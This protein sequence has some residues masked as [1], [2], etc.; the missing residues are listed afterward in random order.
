MSDMML[1]NKKILITG[2]TG[3]VAKPVALAFAENN[4]VWGIAR[5]S[6]PDIKKELEDAGIT[7]VTFDLSEPD[8]SE[9]PNDFDYVLNFAVSFD[10]NFDAT[11]TSIV[12]GL[13]F[14][15]SH[16]RNAKAFI[17]CSTCGVYKVS[18]HEPMKE[19]D[20]LGDSHSAI[21]PAYAICK[22][23]AEGMARFCAKNWNIPTIIARLNVPYGDN[24]GW[25]SLH[26]ELILA[27][28]PVAVHTNKPSLFNPIHEDDIIATI[29][30]LIEAATI[31]ANIVNWA[32]TEQ[33]SL[34]EWSGYIAKLVGKSVD[35]EYTSDTLEST[36]ADTEKM[37]SITGKTKV[38]WQDGIRSMVKARH[39]EIDLKA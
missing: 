39:P 24:G 8:F 16:C 27:D 21:L 1:E 18:G 28:Q 26:M 4:D 7:C 10:P 36:V 38:A 35:L 13:G 9:V 29:P 6:N 14:L 11:I 37:E 2:L 17:H 12:E 22:T 25:P 15:M 31:P 23:A 34:E 5:F 32:G 19:T 3:Q 30:K 33:V 20:P